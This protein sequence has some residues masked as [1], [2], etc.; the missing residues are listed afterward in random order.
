M[1]GKRKNR[2]VQT[3]GQKCKGF[4]NGRG[5]QRAMAEVGLVNQTGAM[6]YDKG[7]KEDIQKKILCRT[8]IHGKRKKA[9]ILQN[10]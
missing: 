1:T 10:A 7:R 9:G 2:P 6:Q 5:L 4:W 3:A 8:Q